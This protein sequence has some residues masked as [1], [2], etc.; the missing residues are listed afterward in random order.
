[1]RRIDVIVIGLALFLSGGGVYLGLQAVGLSEADAGIW[2]QAAL[3][4][5]LV[6]W[7]LTYLWRAAT[8]N[9]TY[10]QQVKDYEEAVLQK[11]YEELSPEERAALQAELERER[12]PNVT[13][14]GEL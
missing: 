13:E 11:R 7:L 3:V 9:M 14:S 12:R 8:Q 6:G 5:G 2:S 10:S 1:M 4:V